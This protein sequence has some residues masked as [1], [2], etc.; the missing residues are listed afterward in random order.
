MCLPSRAHTHTG[1][2]ANLG[3]SDC[4]LLLFMCI[5]G[6]KFFAFRTSNCRLYGR[7]HVQGLRH[8]GKMSGCAQTT[9]T[10]ACTRS[11]GVAIHEAAG[12]CDLLSVRP[13]FLKIRAP[14]AGVRLSGDAEVRVVHCLES[15][16]AANLDG[17]WFEQT[18]RKDSNS[19]W[20]GI[21]GGLALA[22]FGTPLGW[23]L[24][25]GSH[26]EPLRS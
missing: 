25:P 11:K 21:R 9:Q 10:L 20:S 19:V 5:R 24:T 3:A 2:Q 26:H 14:S 13:L 6:C 18:F 12:S 7:R 23:K 17:A 1:T 22:Y 8:R 4:S 16:G 15:F